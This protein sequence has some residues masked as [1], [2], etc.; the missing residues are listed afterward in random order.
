MRS[1]IAAFAFLAALVPGLAQAQDTYTIAPEDILVLTLDTGDQVYIEFFRDVAPRHVER[2][3]GLAEQ[4]FYDGV[5]FHRVIPDFM[6]QG[7][8]PT[9]TGRGG[10]DL[11]NLPAEFSSIPHTR[12]TASMARASDPNSANSQFF[13]MLADGPQPG[14][15]WS[16]LDGSYTIWGRVIEGM[17]AVDNI[18][19]GEPPA[20]PTA[21]AR[22]RTLATEDPSS[23][24]MIAPSVIPQRAAI[25]ELRSEEFDPLFDTDVR[26]D[27][28]TPVLAD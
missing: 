27:I 28:L 20:E 5:I 12:G 25:A 18:N 10:S 22:A 3:S 17:D 6:A 24:G 11:P 8:D 9:G 26:I 21:I 16:Q 23:E 4:G 13:L 15:P 14:Q 19:V 2:I 1:F 7:G